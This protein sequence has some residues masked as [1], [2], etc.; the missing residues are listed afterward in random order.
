MLQVTSLY[1]SCIISTR[2]LNS[3]SLE[4]YKSLHKINSSIACLIIV[5]RT[6][7][8]SC[9]CTVRKLLFAKQISEIEIWWTLKSPKYINHILTGLPVRIC[10]CVWIC[11][12]FISITQKQIVAETLNSI[13]FVCMICRWYLILFVKIGQKLCIQGHI[14]EFYR[15]ST[16]RRNFL[17][18]SF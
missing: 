8:F 18:L 11:V 1:T 17:L 13:L 16:Y 4:K 14:K 15:S 2:K 6:I 7:N 9:P 5:N 12:T 10:V 3:L